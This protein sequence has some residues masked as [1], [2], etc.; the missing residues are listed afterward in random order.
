MP[1]KYAELT[2]IRNLEEESIFSFVKRMFG[3]ENSVTDND[4]IILLFDDE[5]ICDVKK[6]YIDKQYVFGPNAYQLIY[7]R[8]FN[9][10]DNELLFFLKYPNF[11]N[12]LITLSF[13]NIFNKNPKFLISKQY[14]SE[15]NVIYKCNSDEVFSIVKNSF[16][17]IKPI[18]LTAYDDKYFEKSDIVYLVMRTF[19]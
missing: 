9:K 16:N 2:I 1:I 13:K 4:T 3:N 6:E 10:K 18:Y 15:Y 14:C 11:V 8:F 19:K 12:G 17:D 5:T 7:P